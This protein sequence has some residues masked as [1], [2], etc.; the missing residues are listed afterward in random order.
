LSHV[1]GRHLVLG[2]GLLEEHTV[3]GVLE[4][5]H[6]LLLGNL[7]VVANAARLLPPGRNASARTTKDDVEVHAVDADVGI[8]LDAEID[9]LINAEAEAASL[10]E[11]ALLKKRKKY[12]NYIKHDTYSSIRQVHKKSGSAAITEGDGK[13]L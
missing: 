7:L 13:I 10:R 4:P 5:L 3:E 8:V 1:L 6:G 11:A 9:V 12:Q 2:L